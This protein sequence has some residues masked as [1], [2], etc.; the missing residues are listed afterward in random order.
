MQQPLTNEMF[1][2]LQFSQLIA[3]PPATVWFVLWNDQQYR[4]WTSIFGEGSY[5]VSTWQ[6]GARV[7]F[8]TE[9]GSGLYTDI[10]CME[11][12]HRMVFRHLGQVDNF[13]ELAPAAA[14]PVMHDRYELTATPEGTL[15][16]V[17][18]DGQWAQADGMRQLFPL[19]LK[20][21]QQQA[22]NIRVQ[23]QTTVSCT[24]AHAWH[25]FTTP[26]L[27]EQ[28]NFASPDWHCPA[29]SADLQ[30]GGELRTRMEARDGSVGFD[31][32]AHY[33]HVQAPEQLHYQLA[34]GRMVWV[35]FTARPDGTTLV[36]QQ[37]EPE[38][39]HSLELQYAG[40]QSILDNYR[41]LTEQTRP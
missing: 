2:T 10:E 4:Q 31:L 41:S 19:A 6:P 16:Q 20:Q 8:L 5:A 17:W 37:F 24:A 15:L 22:E 26:A 36:T 25:S 30:V 13:E 39:M 40:W 9:D 18:V 34:D 29:A 28:W 38:Y 27:I 14:A 21:V 12:P 11:P 35:H 33:T 23:V 3:A 1:T 7:H 32:V